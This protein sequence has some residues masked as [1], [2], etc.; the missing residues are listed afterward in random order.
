MDISEILGM[1]IPDKI[2]FTMLTYSWALR[3]RFFTQNKTD[4]AGY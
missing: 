4:F 2:Q 1:G 3:D